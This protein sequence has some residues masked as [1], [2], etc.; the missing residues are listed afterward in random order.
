MNSLSHA[1]IVEPSEQKDKQSQ[2]SP[3]E[4][5]NV[6]VLEKA[7]RVP[8]SIQVGVQII[9]QD[10]G[11][12]ISR[13]GRDV[14][15]AIFQHASLANLAEPV[16]PKVCRL[17]EMTHLSESTIYRAM[18]ELEVDGWIERCPQGRRKT[19]GSFVTVRTRIGQRLAAYLGLP[20][21]KTACAQ[22]DWVDRTAPKTPR[23]ATSKDGE[24]TAWE[25]RGKSPSAGCQNDGRISNEQ[26]QENNNAQQEQQTEDKKDIGKKL[27]F[28]QV[29]GGYLPGDLVPLV[30]KGVRPGFL[31]RSMKKLNSNQKRSL[32][33]LVKIFGQKLDSARNT[34]AYLNWII[35]R[36]I[37]GDTISE[38]QRPLLYDAKAV[39]DRIWERQQRIKRHE[40]HTYE[41]TQTGATATVESSG[42]AVIRHGDGRLEKMTL[43]R[44]EELVESRR[45]VKKIISMEESVAWIGRIRSQYRI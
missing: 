4:K 44:F 16:F 30:D 5:V 21:D 6:K 7:R 22:L 11:I 9:R 43:H 32:S 42:D 20:W 33:D 38:R 10:A 14:L 45:F 1:L 34:G 35:T 40:G 37:R 12:Q 18:R 17:Q 15:A 28:I 8:R 39:A 3:C 19:D 29:E 41:D 24:A 26:Y 31:W 36:E 13:R 25:N 27:D 23:L 2:A